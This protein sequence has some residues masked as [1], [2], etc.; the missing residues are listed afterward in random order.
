MLEGAI[1]SKSNIHPD[2]L[3]ALPYTKSPGLG[4]SFVTIEP[5]RKA[6]PM[7]WSNDMNL[8][9]LQIGLA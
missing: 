2:K 5:A 1:K 7:Q 6:P 3:G 8:M 9:Y 4:Q